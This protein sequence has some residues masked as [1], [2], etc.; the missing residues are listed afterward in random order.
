MTTRAVSGHLSSSFSAV[1][2]Q[3]ALYFGGPGFTGIL[4]YRPDEPE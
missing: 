1:E 4:R 3:T 2:I